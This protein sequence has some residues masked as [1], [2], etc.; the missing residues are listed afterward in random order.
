MLQFN[1]HKLYSVARALEEICS[2]LQFVKANEKDKGRLESLL[3]DLT[4]KLIEIGSA[5]CSSGF[6]LSGKLVENLS[7]KKSL[8]AQEMTNLVRE[9]SSRIQDEVSF[10]IFLK[11]PSDLEKYYDPKGVLF[12]QEVADRFNSAIDDVDEAGKCLALGR[13]TACVFHLMRIMEAGL[14]SVAKAL[15]IPYA[16]SWESYLK[17]IN[18]RIEQKY[19][20]KGVQWKKDEPFFRDVAAHL[21][22]VKV[23][24]RNPTM[25]I[26]RSYN[27]E[28]A[29]EVFNATKGFM[30]HIATRLQEGK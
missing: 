30:R 11:I 20:K 28:Q 21:Q 27:A 15:G 18:D 16:P 4:Q 1:P 14:K 22:A 5:L 8:T 25:H 10:G 29:E 3:S 7:S 9:L 19:K 2:G 26:E 13:G 12:G 23:A 17:Q 24:W 6:P